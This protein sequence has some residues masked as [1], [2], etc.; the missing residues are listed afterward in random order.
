MGFE[1]IIRDELNDIGR[2][3]LAVGLRVQCFFVAIKNLHRFEV[4][5]AD[6]DDDNSHW[7]VG[8]SNDLVN[9]LLHVTDDSIGNDHQ[10]VEL[11]IHLRNIG[12]FHQVVSL[13]QD[14]CKVR[15]SV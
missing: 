12:R 2:H 7:E 8:S 6:A 4:R 5:I 13:I 10:D 3:V 11:L 1:V 15:G 9:C 14:V